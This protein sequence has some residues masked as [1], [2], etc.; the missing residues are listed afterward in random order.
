MSDG[1]IVYISIG[2]SD[3][4]LTQAEWSKFVLAISTQV[5][6]LAPQIHGAWASNPVGPWQNACW[7]VEFASEA[8]ALTARDEARMLAGEFQQES[9]AWAI[10]QTEFLTP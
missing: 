9:I 3:D 2:N 6:S 8:T 10:A 7:C 1:L 5:I 4:R